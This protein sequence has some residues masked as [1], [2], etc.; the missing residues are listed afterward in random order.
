MSCQGYLY[1]KKS[2]TDF[3]VLPLDWVQGLCCNFLCLKLRFV[4]WLFFGLHFRFGLYVLRL[5]GFLLR[6]FLYEQDGFLFL[7]ALVAFLVHLV[8]PILDICKF[9]GHVLLCEVK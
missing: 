4:L 1:V 9:F 6:L 8:V 7:D 5:F 2:R 3:S